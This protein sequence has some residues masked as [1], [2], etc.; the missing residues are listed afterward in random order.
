MWKQTID[1]DDDIE[2][3]LE[4]KIK[5]EEVEKHKYLG[6]WINSKGSNIDTV[7]ERARK[8]IGN[9]KS[10]VTKLNDMKLGK[11]YFQTAVL[12]REIMFLGSLLYSIEV[13]FN[14]T[15]NELKILDR[16]PQKIL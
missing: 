10:I 16:S 3:H 14:I 11:H 15:K 12:F 1:K 6:I 2:D 9:I 5:L 13:L 4:G 8:A 7:N